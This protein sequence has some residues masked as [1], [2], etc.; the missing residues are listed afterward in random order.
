MTPPDVRS[1]REKEAPGGDPVTRKAHDPLAAIRDRII[2]ELE[3]SP[4]LKLLTLL[5]RIPGLLLVTSL[6]VLLI[7]SGLLFIFTLIR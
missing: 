5:R 6:F 3:G 7:V 2:D 4:R 1:S